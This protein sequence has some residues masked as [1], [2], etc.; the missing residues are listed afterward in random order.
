MAFR[1]PGADSPPPP[2]ARP[3]VDRVLV[4]A[5]PGVS[6]RSAAGLRLPNLARFLSEAAVAGLSAPPVGSRSDSER[7]SPGESYA[8]IGAGARATGVAGLDRLAF[9]AGD[10]FEGG[11]AE[12]AFERRT[13]RPPE[14]T[15]FTLAG[16][17][18]AADA[19]GRRFG[20]RTGALG[21]ALSGA[22]V[23]RAVL[24]NGD[25]ALTGTA[26]DTYGR[27]PALALAD[28]LGSLSGASMGR[29]LLVA[30]PVAPFGL[31]LAEGPLL[32]A[33]RQHWR[34]R[35]VVWVELS[36]LA[37][38]HAYGLLSSSGQQTSLADSALRGADRLL[39]RLLREVEPGRDAVLLVG[40]PSPGREPGLTM[41]ALRAPGLA[42]GLLSS[43]STRRQGIVSAVDLAPTVL[44]LLGLVR[45]PSM[46]GRPVGVVAPKQDAWLDRL[47]AIE[48]EAHFRDGLV[49]A[50]ATG[51]LAIQLGMVLTASVGGLRR[52]KAADPGRRRRARRS[53]LATASLVL[54]CLLPMT[55]VAAR[56]GFSSRGPGAYVVF[57]G[58]GALALGLVFALFG[59]RHR[60]D[61]LLLALA[62]LFGLL[63]VDAT[64]GSRFQ[65]NGVFGYSPTAG[66]RFAGLGN[67]AYAQLAAS[68][69]LLAALLCAR[70]SRTPGLLLAGAVL[71]TAL[72]V[73]GLPMWGADVGGV[74][75]GAPAF[76]LTLAGL[77]GRRL[78]RR[79]V[80]TVAV[81]TPLL[82]GV[83]AVID[84]GRPELDRTHLG[85][86][87]EAVG[88]DGPG[89]LARV[90]TRKGAA[91]LSTFTRWAWIGLVGLSG[92][93]L[94]HLAFG[95]P[96][97]M[98]ALL[99]DI[100]QLRP[101]LTGLAVVA[102][103]GLVLNDSGVAVSGMVAAVLNPTLVYLTA[104]HPSGDPGS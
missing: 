61:P 87:V 66:G 99:R 50:A 13:G 5:L 96:G 53:F 29:H 81:A 80:L 67:V 88:N 52:R 58:L 43:P 101:A 84:L 92:A 41:T 75:A 90:V 42:P 14:G 85:R 100:P 45:P 1:S 65:L 35:S 91:S 64:T 39:D 30:D 56:V 31:R 55:H 19:A 11:P 57:L 104:P 21:E 86:L 28:H 102:V 8:T 71:G 103:L 20:A 82:V 95:A 51:L 23:Y 74:L 48:A 49:G 6:F 36:D 73:D 69:L 70:F 54:V 47:V 97:R 17:A 4:V 76:A 7:S 68:A 37:R 2:A 89:A 18:L 9:E 22:G 24:A 46:E 44:S 33:F 77:S 59:H 40:V 72:L 63:V 34:S 60:L 15:A 32:A 79:W 78:T 62:L 94:C 16:S 83:F 12:A 25:T 98:R 10:R 26:P 38:A 3:A 27:E 93:L